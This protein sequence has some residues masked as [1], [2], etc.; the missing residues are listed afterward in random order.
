MIPTVTA[1]MSA[2]P[3]RPDQAATG[4]SSRSMASAASPYGAPFVED[5]VC[6]LEETLSRRMVAH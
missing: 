1:H 5:D 6:D 3:A 4:V 2:A